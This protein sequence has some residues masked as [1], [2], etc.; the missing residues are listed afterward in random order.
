[1]RGQGQRRKG[2]ELGAEL[3][4]DVSV[5]VVAAR[6]GGVAHRLLGARS[7]GAGSACFPWSLD[8]MGIEMWRN[9][10]GGLYDL[11]VWWAGWGGPGRLGGARGVW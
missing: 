10:R 11:S 2:M 4:G 3:A 7:W 8:R 6:L 5:G 1:M 9:E